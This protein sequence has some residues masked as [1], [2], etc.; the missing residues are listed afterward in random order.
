MMVVLYL[1]KSGGFCKGI[2]VYTYIHSLGHRTAPHSNSHSRK[3]LK[4]SKLQA[5]SVWATA[6]V[7]EGC[8]KDNV[9]Q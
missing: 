6:V 8:G 3:F 5:R 4:F 7:L 2:S 9:G 1:S